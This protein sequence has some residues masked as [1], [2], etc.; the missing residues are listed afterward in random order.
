M[1]LRANLTTLRRHRLL[2]I[3]VAVL[4][5]VAVAAILAPLLATHD[6]QE[7]DLAMRLRPPS[8][9]H[10]FGTNVLGQDVYS[11]LLYG[12]RTTLL[13]SLACVALSLLIGI[14]IGLAAGWWGG[15][16]DTATMRVSDAFLAFP[17]M[18]L[19]ITLIAMLGPGLDHV[20]IA[21]ALSWFPWY[22]RILRVAVQTV[23]EEPYVDAARAMGLH[24]T[25]VAIRHVL[26]NSLTALVVQATVDLGNVIQWA[27]ALSF[28]GLGAVAPTLEWG[29]E[30]G[31]AWAS[32]LYYWW[33]AAFPGAAIAIT[34][35][36][37]NL[38]GDGLRDAL[39]PRRARTR[40][41]LVAGS[42]A[43]GELS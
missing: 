4:A 11:R 7:V 26:P 23:K 2:A 34:V 12:A 33:T 32:F 30:L 38:A 20:V 28:I 13:A 29:L 39:D 8:S 5:A 31:D 36:A 6:P 9:E 16:V 19:P 21:I 42:A 25:R 1:T 40:G 17:P 37:L 27:V 41:E 14:P 22:A 10:W 18:L 15:W 35:L 24:P 43:V 3:S